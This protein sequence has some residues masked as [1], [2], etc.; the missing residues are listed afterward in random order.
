MQME[1]AFDVDLSAV[2]IHTGSQA[3]SL[4]RDLGAHAFTTGQDIFFGHREYDPGSLKGRE[5]LAHE[6]THVVQQGSG[7]PLAAGV[8]DPH[9][10]AELEAAAIGRSVGRDG[11]M[12]DID[13]APSV[14]NHAAATVQRM[15]WYQRDGLKAADYTN[16]VYNTTT[17]TGFY[18][19]TIW[20]KS[21]RY[22]NIQVHWHPATAN[23]PQE[24]WA[25]RWANEGSGNNKP[26]TEWMKNMVRRT[27]KGVAVALASRTGGGEEYRTQFP[28]LP[29]T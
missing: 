5:L 15:S 26:A 10:A 29:G 25:V 2:R 16:A 28:S 12:A 8:S 14:T 20:H 17:R 13:A 24:N 19:F 3:A 9:D 7:M 18:L 21:D 6:L 23:Y 1:A 11:R 27:P 4:S 22:Y